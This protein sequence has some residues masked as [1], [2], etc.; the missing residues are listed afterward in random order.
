M[1]ISSFASFRSHF[2]RYAITYAMTLKPTRVRDENN[3]YDNDDDDGDDND[4]KQRM[5][6]ND[7]YDTTRRICISV[8]YAYPCTFYA[9]S[10]DV[11]SGNHIAR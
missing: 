5:N 4:D 8:F 11:T 9:N 3:G 6:H 1:Y 2:S 7:E 10:D